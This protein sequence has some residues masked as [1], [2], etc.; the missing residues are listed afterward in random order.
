MAPTCPPP[1]LSIGYGHAADRGHQPSLGSSWRHP[2][3]LQALL[4]LFSSQFCCILC[5]SP[6]LIADAEKQKYQSAWLRQDSQPHGDNL[7]AANL[8]SAH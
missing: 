4:L 1:F 7:A 3:A 6:G 5:S 2:A 8:L